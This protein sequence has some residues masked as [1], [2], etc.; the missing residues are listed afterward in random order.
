MLQFSRDLLSKNKPIRNLSL[1]ANAEMNRMGFLWQA[2]PLPN[3]PHI[4]SASSLPFPFPDYPGHNNTT[5]TTPLDF[6]WHNISTPLVAA[7]QMS[8]YK[9]CVSVEVPTSSTKTGNEA[10]ISARDNY[11]FNYQLNL[12]LP[13][14]THHQR[15]FSLIKLI[16]CDI[17]IRGHGSTI[18]EAVKDRDATILKLLDRCRERNLKLNREKLE[19]K[20]SETPFIGHELT[21]KGGET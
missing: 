20:C 5:T 3:P 21:P 11:F 10:N 17:L 6:L 4:F 7:L 13:S 18:K 19:L 1:P 16:A 14:T 15:L 12:L 2:F 8:R 9:V